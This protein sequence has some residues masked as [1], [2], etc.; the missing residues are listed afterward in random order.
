MRREEKGGERRKRRRGEREEEIG[1]A[2]VS[3]S[4]LSPLSPHFTTTNS[5][6]EGQ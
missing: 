3:F 6:L 4:P 2:N 5:D 1:K